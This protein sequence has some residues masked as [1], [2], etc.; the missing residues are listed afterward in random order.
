MTFF[1]E[2]NDDAFRVIHDRYRA[3]LYAYTRQMLAGT[4]QEP[5]DVVQEIF[6]RAYYALRTSTAHWRCGPGS[7]G[8]PTTAVS[9]SFAARI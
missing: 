2:G 7:T 8:S 9:M 6:L 5:E 1:R 4:S 3:R